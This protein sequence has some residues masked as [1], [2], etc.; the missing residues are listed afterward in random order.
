[1]PGQ[2]QPCSGT[3]MDLPYPLFLTFRPPLTSSLRANLT[4]PAGDE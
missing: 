3:K 2:T 1:M 4:L